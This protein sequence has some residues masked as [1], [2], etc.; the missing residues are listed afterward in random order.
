LAILGV[1]LRA[2]P[3]PNWASEEDVRDWV[4]RMTPVFRDLA[5]NTI[6][7]V[8]QATLGL[9][10][11]IACDDELWSAVWTVAIDMLTFDRQSNDSDAFL[12][13]QACLAADGNT[14]SLDPAHVLLLVETAVEIVRAA[15][16]KRGTES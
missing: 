5:A 6:T 14:G 12:V 8:D 13:T 16:V 1:F 2:L 7:T 10:S 15:G 9:V 3:L 11:A 4:R